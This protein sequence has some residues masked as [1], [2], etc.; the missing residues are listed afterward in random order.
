VNDYQ[1]R[2]ATEQDERK[3]ESFLFENFEPEEPQ[4]KQG[5]LDWQLKQPMGF[6]IQLIDSPDKKIA[7][8]S[9]FLQYTIKT[10]KG[11]CTSAFS[12]STMVS[13]EHR[14]KGLG[15]MIHNKRLEE[16]DFAMS[17]G[18]SNANAKLYSKIGFESVGQ[19]K[20]ALI[21]KAFPRFTFSKA[22][23][24]NILSWIKFKFSRCKSNYEI[25][26]IS[27]LPDSLPS[28]IFEKRL[29]ENS[30]SI[31]HDL[32]YIQWRYVQHPYINYQ[33]YEVS[34]EGSVDGLIIC[35]NEKEQCNICDIFTDN[36]KFSDILRTFYSYT[37]KKKIFSL[38][39]GDEIGELFNRS[40]AYTHTS[41]SHYVIQSSNDKL[42]P[43]IQEG[44]W[45]LFW[46]D[47]DKNR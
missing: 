9:F 12:I 15:G 39:V 40:S 31:V 2:K 7:A 25:R 5:W 36:N 38:F 16:F 3:I 34:S 8:L 11:M 20:F 13:K 37:N 6:N 23:A 24:H 42:K 19:Y 45:C 47:S 17:S 27:K 28:N 32:E 33:I 43:I 1:L 21:Q 44:S 26:V 30:N 29:S 46:G 41:G 14:R 35:R 22:Y 10:I 18:Q 4:L